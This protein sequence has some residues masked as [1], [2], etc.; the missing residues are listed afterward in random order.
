MKPLVEARMQAEKIHPNTLLPDFLINV[1]MSLNGA[2][3]P[4]N[5][6]EAKEIIKY[7]ELREKA[8]Q[9][10]S[11]KNIIDAS[12]LTILIHVL[13]NMKKI[14]R[15]IDENKVIFRLTVKERKPKQKVYEKL[16]DVKRAIKYHEKLCEKLEYKNSYGPWMEIDKNYWT[17]DYLNGLIEKGDHLPFI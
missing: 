11:P 2:A 10:W 4:M 16:G 8:F 9:E 1:N 6:R 13:N 14:Q 7:L 3:E 17:D 12:V 15:T 5:R